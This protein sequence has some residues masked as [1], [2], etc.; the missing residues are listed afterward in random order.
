[1]SPLLRLFLLLLP[2]IPLFLPLQSLFLRL[3]C[4]CGTL[5]DEEELLTLERSP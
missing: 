1:M 4:Q 5:D 3:P 2:T